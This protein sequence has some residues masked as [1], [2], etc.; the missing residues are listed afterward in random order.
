MGVVVEPVPGGVEIPPLGIG[1]GPGGN[2]GGGESGPEH[3][4]NK[5]ANADAKQT[6]PLAVFMTPMLANRDWPHKGE[7]PPS[8]KAALRLIHSSGKENGGSDGTRTRGLVR[9]RHAL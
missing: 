1:P 9:D 2:T 4:P 5:S 7:V 3:A 6:A 8:V